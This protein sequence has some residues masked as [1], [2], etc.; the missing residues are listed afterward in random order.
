MRSALFF[1]CFFQISI[2]W[3]QSKQVKY[4][5]LEDGLSNQQVL[6]I[7]HDEYGFV[8]VA[9][10][11]G[12]NRFSSGIFKPYYQSEKEEGRSVHSNEINT[13]FYDRGM[14]YVGTRSK[15]L[16]V[17]D[18]RTNRFSYYLHD[19]KDEKS[20]ATNDITDIT[21][22]SDGRLWVATY[23]QG[24]Q[25]FDPVKKHFERFNKKKLPA[26]PE[27]GIWSLAQGK[28]E[29]LYIGHVNSG[30]SIFDVKHNQLKSIQVSNTN[31]M[32]P[33]NEVKSL[34]C[35]RRNNVWIGTRKGLAIYNPA[36]RSL[37]QI[38]LRTRAKNGLEPFI[39]TIK[40]VGDEIWIGAE[41]SQL[42]I[43]KPRY[44]AGGGIQGVASIT[45]SDLDR[46][47]N[48]SVQQI[49]PDRFGNVWLGIYGGGVGF[50]SH[51][52]PFFHV[53]PKT[54]LAL[55]G[56]GRLATVS[57]ILEGNNGTMW[58]ATAGN[59]IVKMTSGGELE[60]LSTL[61]D[62]LGDNFLL[63]AFQDSK[64]NKWFGLQRGGLAVFDE[65]SKR[66]LHPEPAQ[67]M[68]EVRAIMEDRDRDIWIAAQEGLFIYHP[69]D[70][71]FQKLLIN[72]P[73]LGDYAPRC[74]VE[75]CHGNVW[76]GTYGQGLYVFNHDKT[77]IYKMGA[78]EMLRSNTINHIFRDKKNNIWIATNEGVTLQSADKAL[79]KMEHV[80][81]PGSDA[82]LIVD[83]LAEDQEGNLW[84][85][86]KS[87]LLRYLT[88]DKR[89][90]SYDQSYGIPVGGFINASVATDQL[91]RIY[92]GMQEG[93]CYFQPADIPLKLNM[94]PVRVSRFTVF[95][96]G[97]SRMQ[98]DK[99]PSTT[100]KVHL[101]H[102]ENSFRVE[103]AVM[104][105][106]LNEL[107]EF[108][109]KLE[110]HDRDWIYL[111][112]EKNIDFR[113]IPYREYELR[114]RTRLKNGEWSADYKRLFID[115]APPF[116]LSNLAQVVYALIISMT[117]RLIVFFY[118]R[119]IKAEAELRMIERQHEQDEALYTERLNFYTNITHEL[120]TPL[121][122]ILGPL[123]DILQDERLS[124]KH[125]N[126]VETVKRS[127]GRLYS[128]VSQ[129]LEFRKVESQHR[130][131]FLREGYLGE[132][133]QELVRK[134][135]ELNTK[136][137]VTMAC[138]IPIPDVKTTFDPEVIQLIVD[139]LLSNAFKYTKR[140]RIEVHL[141]YE[142][143]TSAHWAV[144]TVKDTG[145]GIPSIHLPKIFDRF[146][147]VP[148]THVHGTGVGLALVKELAAI[149]HGAVS[150]SSELHKG[151]SFVVRLMANLAVVDERADKEV[152]GPENDETAAGQSRPLLLLVEDDLELRRYLGDGLEAYYEVI[153]AENGISGLEQAKLRIP[154]V[155]LSDIM[156]PDMDGYEMLAKL[157]AE[158]ETSHIPI[159]FLTAKDTELDRHRG[160]TL[161]VDSYI[162]KPV[163]IE[164]LHGRIENLLLSRKV[165]YAGVLQ[166]ISSQTQPVQQ[167]P[168]SNE[169]LW[170]ENSFVNE[171]VKLVEMH[172]EDEV[173]DASTLAE[174]LHMSQSTLYR[175]L[176]GITG[177]SINH[178]V[179]KVRMHKAAELLRSG[180]YNITE[181]TFMVG[182]NSAVYFRQCF[183]DEFGQLP[184]D[185]Q[186]THLIH[187]KDRF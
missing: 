84:L 22:G 142:K 144:I 13:L 76:V 100:E 141:G 52:K 49:A 91:G 67:R 93:V 152:F 131:L 5:S 62:R 114:I 19:P 186:K 78:G 57:G 16:N 139:N 150:V 175:K 64:K 36:R 132:T 94:S 45:L 122:L 154:D 98:Q 133:L 47:N 44:A 31:G 41:S 179:R 37:Q 163:S 58:L 74:M 170:R 1:I 71:S 24:L 9:T 143:E 111:G 17:L 117:L 3:G 89:F 12:L 65:K 66:W 96:R 15:G 161:G 162:T 46:G 172:I 51:L 48:S 178:L 121:T 2:L 136:Q 55:P 40:E 56:I 156:M 103:L 83:A 85:S 27:N 53:F 119:K 135:E 166:Q 30:M 86:T 169:D 127:A 68:T 54:R 35:D 59:G 177:K 73:M 160:Y 38:H 125:K 80:R 130:S 60:Q 7:E 18:I 25:R 79:G 102:D 153:Q 182:I 34:L 137:E 138:E 104:N 140:G 124:S 63:A 112:N 157:K 146:Y 155:I 26:L 88:G 181:V 118:I 87:G 69:A 99:Y 129:L 171:F 61:N 50:I 43:L 39:Y 77:L 123:D 4:L 70:Q 101:R 158:R 6:D 115:I 134:Y 168:E 174:K 173:L 109:Y 147:K 90:L 116:Y 21:R 110:G 10:E 184:S 185:Y 97:E 23:H 33:D 176:K 95:N 8:W 32:L 106:A 20:I 82:W 164:L 105:Y 11:L 148:L 28:N 128:L 120:R 151:T 29:I 183:R 72:K 92:F 113:N 75:D 180:K 149:H 167:A 42:F 14:L 107:V 108:S 165:L 145:T 187:Q 159:I 81:P 126:L